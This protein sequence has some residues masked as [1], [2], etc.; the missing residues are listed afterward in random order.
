MNQPTENQIIK[1][2][3]QSGYLFEQ[4]VADKLEELDFH[5]ETSWAFRDQEQDKSREL[6]LRA[7]KEVFKDH[8]NKIAI[9]SE[10]LVE[11]KAYENPMV[12]LQRSKNTRE[13]THVIPQEYIFP[14]KNYRKQISE[15]SYQEVPA[16][17][18]LGL[19]AQ[20]Y[21]Y[22]DD[23]KATQFS[24]IV[25][26]GSEWV[27]NHDGI[28][29]ALMLPLAKAFESRRTEI[30]KIS[31]GTEWKYIWLTFPM[32][33]L[34][35]EIFSL[36]VTKKPLLPKPQG[37]MSFIRQL[38]TGNIKGFYLTD[39]VTFEHLE[40]YVKNEIGA[41]SERI[42]ELCRNTPELFTQKQT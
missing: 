15:N 25:R 29:D 4:E 36:E 3:E 26:K 28:Y 40:N 34:R 22:Q 7:I 37:R 20:H 13:K 19:Q 18:H 16:F 35:N 8:K 14:I 24:K 39:F 5:V 41:F 10:L 11:C 9:F 30:L 42:T 31:S 1:A 2:L 23:L 21:Y 6:D 17:I 27:A 32:V 33:I 38:D 12:F